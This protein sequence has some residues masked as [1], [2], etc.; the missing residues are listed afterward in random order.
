MKGKKLAVS[1]VM[2]T[3]TIMIVAKAVSSHNLIKFFNPNT[4]QVKEKRERS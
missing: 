2:C 4:D 1:A 3:F